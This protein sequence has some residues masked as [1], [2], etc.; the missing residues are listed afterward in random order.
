MAIQSCL[1]KVCVFFLYKFSVWECDVI[2]S[3]DLLQAVCI[4]TT[5]AMKSVMHCHHLLMSL[6]A[7]SCKS[8]SGGICSSALV[9]TVPLECW[10]SSDIAV[11][12]CT[13]GLC[14]WTT[15][16][17][18]VT[19]FS[20]CVVTWGNT[21]IL[22]GKMLTDK[23]PMDMDGWC[24]MWWHFHHNVWFPCLSFHARFSLLQSPKCV[25]TIGNNFYLDAF[26]HCQTENS[27]LTFISVLCV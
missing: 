9:P 10:L 17:T 12:G 1:L 24:A 22:R 26:H 25:P 13:C 20:V 11:M 6:C 4:L 23:V 18:T 2:F 15:E 8:P 5:N 19:S 7:W 14:E 3:P 27:A 16:V 21:K